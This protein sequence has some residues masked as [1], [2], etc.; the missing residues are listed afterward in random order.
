MLRRIAADSLLGRNWLRVASSSSRSTFTDCSESPS[1]SFKADPTN[2]TD[3]ERQE[4]ISDI[5]NEMHELFGVPQQRSS[6]AAA[7]STSGFSSSSPS[8][9]PPAAFT[10]RMNSTLSAGADSD[11]RLTHVDA[12]GTASMVDVGHKAATQRTAVA[13][14]KVCFALQDTAIRPHKP[15]L[16]YSYIHRPRTHIPTTQTNRSP[17]PPRPSDSSRRTRSPR[18]TCSP[19]PVSQASWQPSRPLPSSHC[20][21]HLR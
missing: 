9:S 17:C 15:R 10:S 4:G 5:L 21:T 8:A 14:A 1:S 20:A 13:S 18:E 3:K 2:L 6:S 19:W 7:A 12:Q 16:T 11:A